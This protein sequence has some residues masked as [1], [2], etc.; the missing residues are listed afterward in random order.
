MSKTIC[1]NVS[2]FKY[3]GVHQRIQVNL[4]LH[5]EAIVD[6]DAGRAQIAPLASEDRFW[7]ICVQEVIVRST[8]SAKTGWP[9][10]QVVERKEVHCLGEEGAQ[11]DGASRVDQIL[12]FHTIAKLEEE[13]AIDQQPTNGD[14]FL[15]SMPGATF[16]Q[17]KRD[18]TRL[19]A[20]RYLKPPHPR[21]FSS[22]K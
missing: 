4:R 20:E 11:T 16:G 18:H 3:L 2:E 9:Q 10:V 6:V 13:E 8:A 5:G 12:G 1:K 21:Y 17:R 19:A 22:S 7:Q 15:C 14:D